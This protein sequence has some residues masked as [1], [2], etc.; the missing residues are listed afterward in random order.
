LL[1]IK[2]K[3]SDTGK[4]TY[5]AGMEYSQEEYDN[6]TTENLFRSTQE[7]ICADKKA[8]EDFRKFIDSDLGVP[9]NPKPPGRRI[10]DGS[11]LGKLLKKIIKKNKQGDLR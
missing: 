2:R 1:R 11:I 7:I 4:R 5:H 6:I 8:D 10:N 9:W 3:V